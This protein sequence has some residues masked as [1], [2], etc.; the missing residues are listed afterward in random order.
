MSLADDLINL[1][2]LLIMQGERARDIWRDKQGHLCLVG[3]IVH[4]TCRSMPGE[5]TQSFDDFDAL[6]DAVRPKIPSKYRGLVSFN[7]DPAVTEQDI[8]DVINK[9]LAEL[10]ALI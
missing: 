7:D 6:R 5:S 3:A 10:G 8:L 1:R 4:V 2:T 9:A